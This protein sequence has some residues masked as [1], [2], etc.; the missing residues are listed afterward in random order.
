MQI[1][2]LKNKVPEVKCLLDGFNIRMKTIK[3]WRRERKKFFLSKDSLRLC[4]AISE[5][6]WSPRWREWDNG[7]GKRNTKSTGRKASEIC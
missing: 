1:L 2:Q 3:T 4:E 6:K 7:A 5:E